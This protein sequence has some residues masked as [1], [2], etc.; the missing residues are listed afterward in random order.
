MKKITFAG[1]IITALSLTGCGGGG[2]SAN[3]PANS[4]PATGAAALATLDQ[5]GSLPILNRD[6]TVAGPDV[7]TNGVRDDIDAYIASLLGTVAQK[8]AL[9]QASSA[10]TAATITNI[11]DQ[12][13]VRNAAQQMANAVS[14]IYSQYATSGNGTIASEKIDLMEKLTINTKVRFLAYESF[15]TAMSGKTMKLPQGAGCVN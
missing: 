9:R 4:P 7:N 14:C 6:N 12:V 11:V 1:I 5:N 13:A 15:N 8:S 2:G 3:T 10:F